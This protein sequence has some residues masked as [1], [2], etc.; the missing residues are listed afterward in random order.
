MVASHQGTPHNI[1]CCPV[2]AAADTKECI[3]VVRLPEVPNP[4]GHSEFAFTNLITTQSSAEHNS[5][6]TVTMTGNNKTAT[7]WHKCTVVCH[8]GAFLQLWATC[9]DISRVTTHPHA[10]DQSNLPCFGE[11]QLGNTRGQYSSAPDRMSRSSC[12]ETMQYRRKVRYGGHKRPWA[13]SRT[14]QQ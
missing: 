6:C 7:I 2:L 3:P 4:S 11:C 5:L 9:A 13:Q 1:L 10:D 8:R 12:G 14:R